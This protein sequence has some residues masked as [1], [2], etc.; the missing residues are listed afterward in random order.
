MLLHSF[1]RSFLHVDLDISHTRTMHAIFCIEYESIV[2]MKHLN[3]LSKMLHLNQKARE[4]NEREKG[5]E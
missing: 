3:L 5:P 1:L 2:K 4:R